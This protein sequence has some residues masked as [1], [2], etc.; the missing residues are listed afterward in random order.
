MVF[1]SFRT[2]AAVTLLTALLE[3]SALP[4]NAQPRQLQ[5]PAQLETDCL[6]RLWQWLTALWAPAG[7]LQQVQGSSQAVAPS[8]ANR[9][10]TIDPNG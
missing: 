3:L 7:G 10:M 2:V 4:V 1:P 5:A 9:G 6:E 8:D